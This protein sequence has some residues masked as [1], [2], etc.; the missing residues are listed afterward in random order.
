VPLDLNMTTIP[1]P[2]TEFEAPALNDYN[3]Y[4]LVALGGEALPTLRAP[5]VPTDV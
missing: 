1:A 3:V 2:E 4:V 5:K